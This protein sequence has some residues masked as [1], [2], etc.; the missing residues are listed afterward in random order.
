MANQDDSFIREVNEELRSDRMR[1]AWRRYG[2]ILI[3]LAILLVLG[4]AGWRGWEYWQSRQAA[5]SGDVFLSALTAIENGNLD[6]AKETLDQLEA[7]GHGAYPVLAQ[8]RAATLL[9]EDGDT[10]A[11]IS[12]FSRIGKDRSIPAAV[13]DAAKLRAGWLLVDTGTY[14][15]VSAEVE[16]LSSDG[17]PFRFSAREILGL[18]AYRAQDYQQA[19]D[20]FEAIA[21]DS[22]SPRNVL[23]RA[24]ILLEVMTANG[25]ISEQQ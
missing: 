21:N 7:E 16:S 25:D 22:E 24:Q 23:N 2:R 14:D 6:A 11:A 10:A 9:A 13:R 15:Q 4:T 12:A 3:A 8:L 19:A 17:N 18:S 20:W 5:E 1:D